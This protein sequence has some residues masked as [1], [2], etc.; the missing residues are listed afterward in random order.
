[1]KSLLRANYA[2]SVSG[3]RERLIKFRGHPFVFWLIDVRIPRQQFVHEILLADT[4]FI[5]NVTRIDFFGG[6]L[7]ILHR[8]VTFSLKSA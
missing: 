5:C 1:M 8:N 3:F 7:L 6:I 2:G 4:N